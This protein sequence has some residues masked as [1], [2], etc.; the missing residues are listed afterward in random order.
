MNR[1]KTRVRSGALA[2]VALA[3]LATLGVMA[4]PTS[5]QDLRDAF[6]Q[7]E[8]ERAAVQVRATEKEATILADRAKLTAEVAALEQQQVRIEAELKALEAH[9]TAATARREKL[10]AEWEARAA[11]T[12]ELA[13]NVRLAARDLQTM[14][15]LS[16][17][18]AFAPDRVDAIA[19]LQDPAHFPGLEDVSMMV[20]LLQDEIVQTGQV[21]IREASL[22]GR[23]GQRTTGQVLTLGHFTA[24]YEL[25]GEFGF[26]SWSP[27]AAAL[28]AGADL[29][30]GATARA[31]RG[32]LD[33]TKDAVPVDLSGGDAM[34]QN[35]YKLSL[36]QQVRTGGPVVYPILA[37]AV[38]AALLVLSRFYFLNRI[39][40]NTDHFMSEVNTLAARGDWAAAEEIVQRNSR[41]RMPVI[42]VIKAGLAVR[43][44]DRETQESVLQEAI[45]HQLPRVE[46]GIAILAVMGA[47]APLLG[48]LGTVTGMINTFRVITMFGT[49]DPKLMSAGISEAL[50]ATALGLVTAIPIMLLH[51][52]LSRRAEHIIGE[53]EE[54]AVQ[55]TNILQ[56]RR[57]D[58]HR[59]A[60]AMAPAVGRVMATAGGA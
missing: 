12:R 42:E 55:L 25:P 4:T 23:D 36:W 24:A 58:E 22:I 29:P 59:E 15:M 47:V 56:L 17:F 7:A 19:P 54:K 26:L 1:L 20:G 9:V 48:L 33:G 37:L 45:L 21:T 16:H 3:T 2:M 51:T 57:E 18:T 39:H 52:V 41:R 8:Q 34:R 32:Y 5:A 14:L 30:K 35:T 10:T 46:R 38:A 31:L 13:S 50:V 40:A 28:I 53:M 49:G 43:D 6:R 44:R 60:I 11:D 27:Q